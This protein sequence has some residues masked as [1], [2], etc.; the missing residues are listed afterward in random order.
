MSEI[1]F[2]S[3]EAWDGAR[4]VVIF[5]A[6]VGDQRVP[7]AISFEALQDQNHFRGDPGPP[8]DTFRRHRAVIEELARKF[9]RQRRFEP[10]GSIFIRARDW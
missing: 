9:I 7:C 2:L 6:N 1:T 10:D 5:W 3:G 8:L 4:M